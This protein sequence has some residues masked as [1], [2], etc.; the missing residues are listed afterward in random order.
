MLTKTKT[1]NA[2]THPNSVFLLNTDKREGATG[3]HVAVPVAPQ[4]GPAAGSWAWRF[5]VDLWTLV[6]LSICDRVPVAGSANQF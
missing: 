4:Q 6:S 5:S 1:S 3:R 2:I